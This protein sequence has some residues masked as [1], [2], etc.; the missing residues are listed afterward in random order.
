MAKQAEAAQ[1]NPK[2]EEKEVT[3]IWNRPAKEKVI[4]MEPA[5]TRYTDQGPVAGKLGVRITVKNGIHTTRNPQEI[6]F[7]KASKHFGSKGID[8]FHIKR[9]ITAEEELQALMKKHSLTKEKI[10]AA[11]GQG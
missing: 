9:E 6:A 4:V 5:E 10:L 1:A 7:L 8:G 2:A 11:T 3:F